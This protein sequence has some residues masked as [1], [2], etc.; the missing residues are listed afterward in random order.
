MWNI[1]LGVDMFQYFSIFVRFDC[2]VKSVRKCQSR[3]GN[4]DAFVMVSVHEV[5]LTLKAKKKQLAVL[6]RIYLEPGQR[7]P[8]K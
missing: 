6:L 4:S 3:Y 2:T 8:Q 7:Q 5:F 1:H